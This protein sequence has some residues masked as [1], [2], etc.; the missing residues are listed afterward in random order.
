MLI[1]VFQNPDLNTKEQPIEYFGVIVHNS[2]PDI[3]KSYK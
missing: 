2:I 1:N 3:I